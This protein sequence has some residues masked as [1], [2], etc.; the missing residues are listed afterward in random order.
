[1]RT[2][3]AFTLTFSFLFSAF[4][5]PKPQ[6]SVRGI[7]RNLTL[8]QLP[9]AQN[10]GTWL[11]AMVRFLKDGD[12]VEGKVLEQLMA[13]VEFDEGDQEIKSLLKKVNYLEA[14]KVNQDKLKLVLQ[15]QGDKNAKTRFHVDGKQVKIALRD[16]QSTVI[17][18]RLSKQ[19]VRLK[20]SGIGAA[21][22]GKPIPE[23]MMRLTIK[24]DD[25]EL[26]EIA[27]FD[28]DAHYKVELPQELLSEK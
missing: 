22:A 11:A 10:S 18:E 6:K 17:I 15:L 28:V 4:T 26:L 16:N 2:T 24:N 13:T 27:G 25:I 1:M 19:R 3:L 8:E 14:K 7:D 9:K 21:Y 12:R 23:R 5:L 20:M